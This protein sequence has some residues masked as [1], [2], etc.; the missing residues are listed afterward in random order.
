MNTNNQ[1]LL[2][3]MSR[4]HTTPRNAGSLDGNAR[5]IFPLSRQSMSNRHQHRR[6]RV[7]LFG[8]SADPPTGMGGHLGIVK[9][10]ASSTTTTTTSSSSSNDDEMITLDFDEI[11]VLPV[12]KHMFQNKRD[13]KDK[14]PFHQRMDMCKLC[15]EGVPNVVVSDAEKICYER[16]LE[17]TKKEEEEE[18]GLENDNSTPTTPT[19]PQMVG[20]ADILDMLIENEPDVD[21]TWAIGEDAFI[22]LAC[23]KWKRAEDI[24]KLLGHRIVVF[25]RS[26]HDN[27]NNDNDNEDKAK[28]LL[29]NNNNNNNDNEEM[30]RILQDCV[31]KWS[32]HPPIVNTVGLNIENGL[33]SPSSSSIKLVHVPTLSSNVSSSAARATNDETILNTLLSNNVL[34]YIRHH[35]MYSFSES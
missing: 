7:C 20:T 27:N 14:A 15:F 23:G 29:T 10:L 26:L 30:E 25:R 13:R 28:E 4:Q 9:Y 11:R 2:L 6:R 3:P 19:T 8:T 16:Y 22:D 32:L 18:D 33:T 35:C 31:T 1:R 12:Y 34:D 21:F 5:R 24:F 17:K